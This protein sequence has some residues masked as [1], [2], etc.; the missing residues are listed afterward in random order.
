M[1][2]HCL[3]D[4][5]VFDELSKVQSPKIKRIC[6]YSRILIHEGRHTIH[7]KKAMANALPSRLEFLKQ[8]LHVAK[9]FS[10]STLETSVSSEGIAGNQLEAG[11][12]AIR[13]ESRRLDTP[14][15]PH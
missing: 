9:S 13:W 10:S 3:L 1:V 7:L 15:R 12:L 4:A 14:S 5:L 11:N 6:C 8:L 2:D